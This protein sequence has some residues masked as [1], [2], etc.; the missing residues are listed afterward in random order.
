MYEV[1]DLILYGSTGVCKVVEI[2][3]PNLAGVDKKQLYY[4]LDPLYQDGVIYTPVNNERVFMR[5]VISAEEAER[6]IAMIPALR[7]EAFNSSSVQELSA[8]YQ[9]ALRSYDCADL[10]EL[11]MSIYAKKQDAEHQKRKI[12]QTDT[13][14]MKQAED[15]LF[16]ELAVA[17]DIPIQKVPS[18][19]A[20]K[21]NADG[22][23]DTSHPQ[24][25]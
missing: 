2:T 25:E 7:A 10:I 1:G 23:W 9:A 3:V 16:G 14:F 6:L 20:A 18:Y 22:P 4:V 19:I 15:M 11:T 5:P 24:E 8:H 12:G 13:R 21:V 17:L